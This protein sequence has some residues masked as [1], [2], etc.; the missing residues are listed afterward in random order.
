MTETITALDLETTGLDTQKDY[1]IQIGLI[2]F[3]SKTWEII[4]E[5]KWYIKPAKDFSID[6]GAQEKHG[7][8][9]E[10]LLEN[11][12]FLKDV[13]EEAKEIIGNDDILSYNGNC[14]DVPM[15]Y[16]N[17]ARNGLSFDFTNRMFLDAMIIEKKRLQYNLSAAYK[18]YTGKELE[19]A[20]D[21][22]QD[23]KATIEIFKNQVQ[24]VPEIV[25]EKSNFKMVSPEGM[26][27]YNKNG[28][29][30]FSNGK[31]KN[32]TTNEICKNDPLYIKWIF[33]KF[34]PITCNSIKE[35]YMAE[36]AR[37]DI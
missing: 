4:K 7:I 5:K 17:L 31:Y 26:V 22:L 27:K 24:Q 19:G 3:D 18:R 1:I 35:S 16:F 37:K 32:K 20:H 23:V 9:K 33:E 21:A 25:E 30:V 11:G 36:K 8:T 13:W 15:L 2:K 34:S 12:V 28:E 14:F 10:F 6:P 29:L